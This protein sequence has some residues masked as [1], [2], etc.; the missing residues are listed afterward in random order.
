MYLIDIIGKDQDELVDDLLKMQS[1]AYPEEWKYEDARQYYT[2]MIN[3]PENIN[4]ILREDEK[5]IGYLLAIPHDNAF[6]EL[7][8]V[9]PVMEKD[10][11]RFYVETMEI[12]P[13]IGKTLAG[14]KLCFRM[15]EKLIE[16]AASRDVYKFSM[17]ARISTGLSS[18]VKRRFKGIITSTRIIES[19][20]YYNGQESTEYMLADV[21]II[22]R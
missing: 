19:W 9:D 15:L 22:D 1:K 2:E 11:D 5:I 8:V 3:S 7:N 17:H 21:R 16:E 20:P 6:A 13:E 4:I 10:P 14:G 18:A 12:D